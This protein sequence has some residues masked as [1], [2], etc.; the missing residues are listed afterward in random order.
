[1][2]PFP[3][4]QASGLKILDHDQDDL[5][6]WLVIATVTPRDSLIDRANFDALTQEFD[7]IG[8][9]YETVQTPLGRALLIPPDASSSLDAAEDMMPAMKAGS[10]LDI[11]VYTHLLHQV[12]EA[13]WVQLDVGRRLELCQI[14]CTHA[15]LALS[16]DPPRPGSGTLRTLVENEARD[17]VFT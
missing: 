13:C 7:L 6:Y 4:V 12:T 17:W 16:D 5:M 9:G 8:E 1:M 10:V 11:E 14:A 3:T 15:A 2:K